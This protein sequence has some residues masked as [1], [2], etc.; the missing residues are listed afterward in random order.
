MNNIKM[1]NF[2]LDVFN[3]ILPFFDMYEYF[4]ISGNKK[5]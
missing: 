4:N 5:I 1:L 3:N 2:P